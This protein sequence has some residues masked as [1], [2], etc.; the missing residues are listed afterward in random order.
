R[1]ISGNA[2]M[3]PRAIEQA[4]P[5]AD[6]GHRQIGYSDRVLLQRLIGD[7]HVRESNG[8]DGMP[9]AHRIGIDL[10]L[11]ERLH[12]RRYASTIGG[13]A[14]PI[15][16]PVRGILHI[17]AD[18]AIL[19]IKALAAL[20]QERFERIAVARGIADSPDAFLAER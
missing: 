1:R 11:V 20:H 19:A 14:L 4:R 17:E 3:K 6:L 7:E 15:A 5:P 8:H 9:P 2:E 12:F 16:V 10:V 13:E 18:L